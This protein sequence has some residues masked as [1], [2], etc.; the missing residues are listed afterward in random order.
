MSKNKRVYL[1]RN[2]SSRDVHKSSTNNTRLVKKL[3]NLLETACSKS[4]TDREEQLGK[5]MSTDKIFL[6]SL[7]RSQGLSRLCATGGA[8]LGFYTQ[9][10]SGRG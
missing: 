2:G 8:T 3:G 5:E 4:Q 1:G 6:V 10:P 9:D 7:D